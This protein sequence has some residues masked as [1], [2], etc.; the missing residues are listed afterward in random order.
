MSGPIHKKPPVRR[1]PFLCVGANG[2]AINLVKCIY[3]SREYASAWEVIR[4]E[5]FGNE[6]ANCTNTLLLRF[7][8]NSWHFSIFGRMSSKSAGRQVKC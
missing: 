6:M 1:A 4:G 3:I 5:F 7:M 2:L 8:S